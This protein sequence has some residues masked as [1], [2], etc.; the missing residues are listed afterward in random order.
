[1]LNLLLNNPVVTAAADT[2]AKVADTV[3]T[4][5]NNTANN[6]SFFNENFWKALEITGEG[7]GG[8]LAFMF[9][10][11]L[12]ILGMDKLFPPKKEEDN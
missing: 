5:V 8:I 10:F 3:T 12:I 7:M 6:G 2:T 4:A 11:Y 9:V 1:M